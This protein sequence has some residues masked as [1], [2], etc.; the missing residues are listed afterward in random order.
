M[1]LSQHLTA[2][3]VYLV[4]QLA[5]KVTA[6]LRSHTFLGK[7]V[8]GRKLKMCMCGCLT[9]KLGQVAHEVTSGSQ[10]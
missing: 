6:S 5:A 9:L 4:G 7:A 10:K 2:H 3:H 8:V 1:V